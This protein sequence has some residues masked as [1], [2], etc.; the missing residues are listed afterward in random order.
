ML[1]NS[2]NK[3]CKIQKVPARSGVVAVK[4]Q[5]MWFAVSPGNIRSYT[6]GSLGMHLRTAIDGE[7]PGD[8]TLHRELQ[9]A[10]A[11]QE[12]GK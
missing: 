7:S 11:R 6:N 1:T 12:R 8:S 5:A 3:I 9:V 10:K 2:N 4:H